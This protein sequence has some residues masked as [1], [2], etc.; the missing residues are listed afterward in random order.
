MKKCLL[1]RIPRSVADIDRET[2][3]QWSIFLNNGEPA[4]DVHV[5]PVHQLYSQWCEL[6]S[7]ETVVGNDPVLPDHVVLLLPATWT[8]NRD[9]VINSGQK[10]HIRTALPFLI[11]EDVAGDI[12]S[13]HLC[14]TLPRK[15][16]VAS[17]TA[18][19]H[20]KIKHLLT[21]FETENLYPD[22]I[23]AES[24]LVEAVPQTGV[25]VLDDAGVTLASPGHAPTPVGYEAIPYVL[26][27][28]AEQ[29]DT[30]SEPVVDEGLEDRRIASIQLVT[31][32][33]L[34]EQAEIQRQT[35]V[36]WLTDQGWLFKEAAYSGSTF[37]FYTEHY[38]KAKKAH[39]TGLINL[40]QGAYQCPK[41]ASRR[42]KQW[43]PLII[44]FFAGLVINL[45]LIVG[46][47][48]YFGGE[49]GSL[50]HDN[51]DHYLKLYPN[52]RQVKD[53]K[54]RDRISFDIQSWLENRLK[55]SGKQ[56]SSADKAFLP[57]LQTV[58]SVALAQG[59]NTVE[60]KSMDFNSESG[61]LLVEFQAPNLEVVN[62]MLAD[63]KASGLQTQL[64]TANQEKA[65]VM[66]RVTVTR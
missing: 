17:L 45:G 21:L 2:Q 20:E 59:K 44:V 40:R 43:R 29:L 48:L 6:Y 50:W 23:Y 13:L 30:A 39:A 24:R 62:K 5:S 56:L 32:E 36:D 61:H 55:N 38:F 34:S 3:V 41:R 33:G 31:P 49:A 27:Q 15:G 65:G 19:A 54:A 51:A 57:L 66:A 10:K 58:S 11:E 28:R 35:L 9:V 63:L 37:D 25:I 8:I 7:P 14:H 42:I 4:G 60:P 26:Q 46:K 53:A 52:D 1:V 12:E 64:D 16:D 22:T 47:G 18:I